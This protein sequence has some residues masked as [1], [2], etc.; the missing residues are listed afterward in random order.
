MD[1][2]ITAKNI[3]VPTDFS[4]HAEK[5][6]AKLTRFFGEDFEPK[7]ALEGVHGKAIVELTI[8]HEGLFFRAEESTLGEKADALDVCADKIIRQIRKNKTKIHK[9][10]REGAFEKIDEIA[11]DKDIESMADETL[12]YDKNAVRVKTF[13]LRPT[14]VADAIMQMNLLG[15]DFFMFQ[16]AETGLVSVVYKRL[17]GGY[18]LIQ[19]SAE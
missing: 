7:I 14:D 3:A 9:Q 12:L 1:I 2:K 19:P 17:G 8:A 15:H 4:T 6:L 5:K 16:N 13:D 11:P 10:L 18:A